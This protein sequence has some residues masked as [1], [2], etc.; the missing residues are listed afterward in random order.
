VGIEIAR[1][2]DLEFNILVS[3]KLPFPEN[4][5]TGFG[6]VAEDGSIYIQENVIRWVPEETVRQIIDQQTD[7]IKRRIFRLRNNR[8]FPD[9]SG[10]TV[11][12]TD[13][14]I[15]MGSTLRAAI[16]MC[17]NKEAS[18]TVVA[19]PV[20]GPTTVSEISP[21]VD[22]LIVLEIPPYFRAVAQAYRNWHDVT[23]QEVIDLM[24]EVRLP[25]QW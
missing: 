10:R 15:A 16:E 11:V 21:L 20:C 1:E 23:D 25:E 14:G 18:K 6:A 8:P 17:K 9:I 19:V 13:D 5:E 12:L 7:V 2:L 3:R 24:E 22:E 4:P